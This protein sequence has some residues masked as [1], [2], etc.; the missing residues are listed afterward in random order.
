MCPAASVSGFYLSHPQSQYFA[1]GKI[2]RDQVEDYAR[3]KGMAVADVERWLAPLSRLR[4][5]A[6]A[7][8]H[9][10][11]SKPPR[12]SATRGVNRPWLASAHSRHRPCAAVYCTWY[13][14]DERVFRRTTRTIRARRLCRR[15]RPGSARRLRRAQG[16]GAKR[17]RCGERARSSSRPTPD[18]RARRLRT[19]RR[20]AA[21]CA[22][23]CRRMR[24]GR[25]L[26]TGAQR[27][28]SARVSSSCS[29]HGS[30]CRRRT[31]T[32]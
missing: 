23:C 22:G 31:T 26:R 13:R 8:P 28:R 7:P 27:L 10:K 16:C 21:R 4:Q 20:A 14:F 6:G 2:G 29:G 1:V 18:T 5:Y 17:P 25:C 24:A 12:R 15:A 9:P 3:R 30:S 19:M 11:P 32:A